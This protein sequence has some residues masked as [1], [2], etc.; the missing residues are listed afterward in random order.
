MSQHLLNTDLP[1]DYQ[2]T[3]S[4][5]VIDDDP[6]S[7]YV[8]TR[9]LKKTDKVE[10]VYTVGNG[11]KGIDYL[12][13]LIPN[14]ENFPELIL[15]DVNMPV[16]DGWQFL[17]DFEQLP[18]YLRNRTTIIMMSNMV[19][20]EYQQRVSKFDC[21]EK[22]ISKPIDRVKVKRLVNNYLPS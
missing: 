7:Q 4:A 14:P 18:A 10:K 6:A 11:K 19:S 2:G 17:N 1:S 20:E 3:F 16:A 21:V 5:L 8:L 9:H 12:L 15:L 13:S 22:I